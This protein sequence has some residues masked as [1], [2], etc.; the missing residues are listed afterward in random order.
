MITFAYMWSEHDLY[1]QANIIYQKIYEGGGETGS[2]T[3][4]NNWHCFSCMGV[5]K[6]YFDVLNDSKLNTSMV[7]VVCKQLIEIKRDITQ[8]IEDLSD[9]IITSVEKQDD[10]LQIVK[11]HNAEA[12]S[13]WANAVKMGL[14][15]TNSIKTV[16]AVVKVSCTKTLEIEEKDR[17]IIMFKH[18]ESVHVAFPGTD[19]YIQQISLPRYTEEEPWLLNINLNA[20]NTGPYQCRH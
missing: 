10:S 19:T 15:S 17:S 14:E 12:K 3:S 6:R 13:S 9:K 11:L 18:R 20:N 4:C 5:A 8:K 16:Q 1:I 2:K 7:K